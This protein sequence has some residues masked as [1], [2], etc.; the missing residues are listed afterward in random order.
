MLRFLW[1]FY[2]RLNKITQIHWRM[3]EDFAMSKRTLESNESPAVTRVSF[4]WLY[5]SIAPS[6]GKCSSRWEEG[7]PNGNSIGYFPN[8]Y[9][10]SWNGESLSRKKFHSA[11][12]V[13]TPLARPTGGVNASHN[14]R[15]KIKDKI[16]K[17]KERKMT[18]ESREI[19]WPR[20]L[21]TINPSTG[22][23]DT[24]WIT[25]L[26]TA[27][28]SLSLPFSFISVRTAFDA[29]V[30][31]SFTW[32][33]FKSFSFKWSNKEMCWALQ[34]D[35]R[36]LCIRPDYSF[37]LTPPSSGR[38]WIKRPPTHDTREVVTAPE[39]SGE[40]RAR[41]LRYCQYFF[42]FSTRPRVVSFRPA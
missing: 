22:R 8:K 4:I 2:L 42:W 16:R 23:N 30:V 15:R 33:P 14:W 18:S 6:C 36:I 41:Q 34:T 21:P 1:R 25:P 5:S 32:R 24:N 9:L 39:S 12:A 13:V 11:A 29:S 27:V 31:H 20:F 35:K 37:N 28:L 7:R 19:P 38:I 26:P 40:G 10:S 3:Y 17:K